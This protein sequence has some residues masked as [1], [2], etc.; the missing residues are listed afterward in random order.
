MLN[1]RSLGIMEGKPARP[2]PNFSNGDFFYAPPDGDDYFT[3]TA[4]AM[5]FLTDLAIWVEENEKSK[6]LIST[7]MGPLRIFYAILSED[8]NSRK[9]LGRS[10]KNAAVFQFQWTH[11]VPPKFV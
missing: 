11:L 5:D 8:N 9:V 10:F 4:R 3:V 7:H 1:E 6:I 2:I